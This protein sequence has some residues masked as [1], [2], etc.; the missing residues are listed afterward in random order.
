MSTEQKRHRFFIL[1]A[2]G[3]ANQRQ[4]AGLEHLIRYASFVSHYLVGAR[5]VRRVR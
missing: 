5:F 4:Y 1:R 2:T 3:W